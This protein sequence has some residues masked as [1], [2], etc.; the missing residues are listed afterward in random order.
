M[1]EFIRHGVQPSI[2]LRALADTNMLVKA[3][4]AGPPTST[5]QIGDQT[6]MGIVI[7]ANHIEGFASLPKSPDGEA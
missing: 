7:A 5:R 2:A 4:P 3:E 1:D 6:V